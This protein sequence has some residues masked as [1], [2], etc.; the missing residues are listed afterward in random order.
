VN[1]REPW[2]ETENSGFIVEAASV[3]SVDIEVLSLSGKVAASD[4]ERKYLCLLSDGQLLIAQGQAMNPFVLSYCARLSRHG[5]PFRVTSAPIEAIG[6]HYRKASRHNASSAHTKMQHVAKELLSLACE[7]QASDIHI[8]VRSLA[9][10]MYFRIHND[11]IRVSGQTREYGERLLATLYGA[12]TSVSDNAY[13]P[14]ER[15]DAS[16]ADRDKLPD[17][18]IGVRIATTP[19]SDGSLM[20]LRLLYNDAGDAPDLRSLGFNTDQI[21]LLQRLKESPTGLNI[22]SGPAGSGKST[23]LQR[24]LVGAIAESQQG[25]HVITVEDPVEYPISGAVQTPVTNAGTEEERSRLFSAAISNAMRL[26]PDTIMVGE[27]RDCASAQSAL[28]AA[29]TGHQVW[30]TVHSS[31]AIGIIDRLEDLGLPLRM[32][33][34][35]SVLTGLIA[36]RLVKLLCPSCKK[37]FIDVP[38]QLNPALRARLERIAGDAISRV[39]IGGSGCTQCRGRGTIG[40]TVLAEMI[41]P[42]ATFCDYIRKGD[43]IGAHKYWL[44]GMRGRTMLHQAI[45]RVNEGSVDP[46]MAER[47]VGWLD[48]DLLRAEELDD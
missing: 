4:E 2:Q 26:D 7:A 43:K 5:Y 8:R 17:Q 1:T 19:T 21:G 45:D 6:R 9:T 46:Q 16:I 37:R 34:D 28:R 20:V 29:M 23:S 25:I 38:G 32:L 22:I 14:T 11:M 12:M 13:K 33:V 40:R 41:M 48:S 18:L 24:I 42:D 30:T 39:H 31:S 10:E 36:Q 35:P 44:R 27:V 3:D 15:Q 47:A